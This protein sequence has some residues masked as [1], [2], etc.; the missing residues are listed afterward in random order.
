MNP[1]PQTNAHFFTGNYAPIG[2]EHDIAALDIEGTLPHGLSG[3]LYRVGPSPQYAPRDDNYHWFSGD[4]MVHAFHIDAGV[5]SYRNRWARTPKWQLEHEAGRA[6]FG[7]FGNPATSDPLAQGRNGGT[8]N[9]NMLWHGNRLFALEESH[10]PFELDAHTLA[11]KGH[12]SFGD[13]VNSRCTAHPKPDPESGELHFFA[14]SPD[15]PCSP[16]MLYGVMDAQC[17]V[18]QLQS[19]SAPYAS[20][21]HDFMVT[22]GHVLFP[23]TP[24]TLSVERAMR[25]KPLLAWDASLRTHVGVMR[26]GSSTDTLRW[27]DTDACHVFHVMNAWDDGDT[28]VAYVMQSDTAPGLP[29]AE[30][31]PGDPEA[32]AARLC[33]WT[34]DL[35]GEHAT[36]RREYLDDLA[37]EF[38][39]IDER[40]TGRRNRYGFYTCHA[41]SRA[42]DDAESV[43]YDSLAR[44]DFDS[45]ERQMYTLPPGDVVSEPVFVPRSVDAAE[46][47]GWLLTVA[48]REEERR[49]DLLVFDATNVGAGAV[50]VARLPHRVPFGFHGNW[51]SN[52]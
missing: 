11:S 17:E 51:R 8:A 7:T 39:R 26:R 40:Y 48:W 29:D 4:G 44:F 1:T 19:F 50:A 23:V 43:L 31:R 24:L 37:A 20:M 41:T 22:R 15:G 12:Q 13:R 5:V 14:Y 28:V 33:R 2:E 49:S 46:G 18:T 21:A 38:P 36:F 45:G 27:F 6:L 32:M 16:T 47:D 3:S 42:R 52:A 34:F 10:Q 35:A 30:G 9:T 25:G